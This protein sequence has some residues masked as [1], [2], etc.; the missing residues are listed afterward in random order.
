MSYSGKLSGRQYAAIGRVACEWAHVENTLRQL[1]SVITTIDKDVCWKVMAELGTISLLNLIYAVS[2]NDAKADDQ[3]QPIYQHLKASDPMLQDLR[4][5]RN[6][7]VHNDWFRAGPRGSITAFRI[8]A[9][10][11]LVMKLEVWKTSKIEELA[12]QISTFNRALWKHILDYQAGTLAALPP[13]PQ[14][15]PRK[16]RKSRK[17]VQR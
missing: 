9:K 7:I 13:K 16:D 8:T 10:G 2:H 11:K 12:D 14:P 15:L 3:Q 17:D 1:F 4:I 6:T 5:K